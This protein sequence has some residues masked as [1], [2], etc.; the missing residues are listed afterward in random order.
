MKKIAIIGGGSWGTALALALTRARREHGVALWVHDARLAESLAIT[1]ENSMYMPE[2]KLPER[3][4]V[5]AELKRALHDAH[6]VVGVMPSAHAREVYEAAAPHLAK[7]AVIVSVTKGLEL[8]TSLRMSEV[9]REVCG[10]EIGA[11]VA[12]LSGPSF[13]REVA[14]GDPTAVVI[15]SHDAAVAA[16]L[17]D[18][19]SG[20]TLRL[21]TND[22]VVGVELCGALKNVIAIAAGVCAGIGLGANT[23][24][25][26]VTRGLAEITRLACAL[27]AKRDTIAGLAGMGDLVLTCTGALSRNRYVGYELGAGRTLPEILSSMRMVAEGVGTAATALDLAK[28]AGGI[29]MPITEQMHAVLYEGRG[30]K[31][32]IRE[33][34]ERRLKSE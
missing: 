26:L 29:E 17:Q 32:A 14:R 13:A 8:H 18:E 12:V 30:P 19:F 3:V 16:E 9:I 25:S 22:D 23:T 15:A 11:R 4:E 5:T 20:A 10:A 27:G 7:D 24:A 28:R 21:Y 1:R 34:M 2:Y 6:I 33:L 31:D